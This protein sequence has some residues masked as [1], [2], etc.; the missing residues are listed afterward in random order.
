V[1]TD[2]TLSSR[3]HRI[4]APIEPGVTVTRIGNHSSGT[5]VKCVADPI[6]FFGKWITWKKIDVDTAKITQCVHSTTFLFLALEHQRC[7]Y[8]F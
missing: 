3:F 5:F 8:L 6:H 1:L 2:N 4:T 7:V